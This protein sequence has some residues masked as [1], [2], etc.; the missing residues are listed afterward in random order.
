[1]TCALILTRWR[2]TR[3]AQ[4]IG[5]AQSTTRAVAPCLSYHHCFL[6]PCLCTRFGNEAYRPFPPFCARVPARVARTHVL[7]SRRSQCYLGKS[8]FWEQ[9]VRVVK[10][11]H[12]HTCGASQMWSTQCSTRRF[13][14]VHA[15][16]TLLLLFRLVSRIYVYSE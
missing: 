2:R 12:P 15:P 14:M 5:I 4:S 10:W 1:M 11:T 16:V 3:P 8:R 6:S 7:N 13:E 9:V